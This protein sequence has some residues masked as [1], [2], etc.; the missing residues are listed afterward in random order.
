MH[1]IIIVYKGTRLSKTTDLSSPLS[2]FFYLSFLSISIPVILLFYLSL[3]LNP[4]IVLLLFLSLNLFI[5]HLL[6][7]FQSFQSYNSCVL[8]SILPYSLFC[9]SLSRSPQRS[10]SLAHTQPLTP[11]SLTLFFYH[12]LS[13]SLYLS[14]SWVSPPFP[15]SSP[16]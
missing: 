4:F 6:S 15:V 9:L 10:R 16:F 14:L 7:L 3:S 2:S 11:S 8:L 12:L 5:Y 13:F 1:V